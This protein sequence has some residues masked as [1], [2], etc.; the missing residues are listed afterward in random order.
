MV[1]PSDLLERAEYMLRYASEAMELTRTRSV[2]ELDTDRTFELALAH[3]IQ[4][5]G[6]LTGS[7]AERP[8]TGYYVLDRGAE[9]IHDLRNVIVHQFDPMDRL[10]LWQTATQTIPAIIPDLQTLIAD[11]Q[12]KAHQVP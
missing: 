12:Q 11:L 7:E 2:Q 9:A 1:N 8:E 4:H 10:A 6:T 5:V 3:L